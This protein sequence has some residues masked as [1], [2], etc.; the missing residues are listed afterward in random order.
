LHFFHAGK[1]SIKAKSGPEPILDQLAKDAGLNISLEKLIFDHI[2]KRGRRGFPLKRENAQVMVKLLLD[3]EGIPNPFPRL[4]PGKSW[5]YGLLKRFPE[6]VEKA[7]E[8]HSMARA[9]VTEKGI[10]FWF[11]L[12][13]KCA[14]DD[15]FDHILHDPTRVFNADETPFRI[16]ETTGNL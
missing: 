13:L 14:I 10:K 8:H 3:A 12:I 15:K 16:C 6:L 11:N 2:K 5:F 7:A 4:V 1:T 9:A